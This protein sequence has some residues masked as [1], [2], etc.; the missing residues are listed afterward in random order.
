[1]QIQIKICGNYQEVIQ[2]FLIEQVFGTHP[3][4]SLEAEDKKDLK[5]KLTVLK[6][7]L[8]KEERR[9]TGNDPHLWTYLSVNEKAM[10]DSVI[11]KSRR[12]AGMPS[13]SNGK[14]FHCYTNMA[15]SIIKKKK[16]DKAK[17][18]SH[19]KREK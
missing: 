7:E 4:F 17:G 8:E 16:T 18:G 12:K 1:M 14:P 11:L 10:K 6:D 19:Q 2:R 3:N 15:E 5:W 13:D 9:I